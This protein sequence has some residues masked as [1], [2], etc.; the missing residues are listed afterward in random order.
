MERLCAISQKVQWIKIYLYIFGNLY[1]IFPG[2][3]FP[4][5]SI[6]ITFEND[7]YMPISWTCVLYIAVFCSFGQFELCKGY[8]GFLMVPQGYL[9][10]LKI[11][12]SSLGLVRVS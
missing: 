5:L 4:L 6:I 10:F 2:F 11:C 3:L 7:F 9:K 1:F 12:Y 8:Y